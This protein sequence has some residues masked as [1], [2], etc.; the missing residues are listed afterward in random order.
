M[1]VKVSSNNPQFSWILCKNPA[2][3]PVKKDIRQGKGLGFFGVNNPQ[4]YYLHFV[5]GKS[6]SSFTPAEVTRSEPL[7]SSEY[8]HPFA[9]CQLI[10]SLLATAVTDP[11][12]TDTYECTVST[13]VRLA[14][15]RRVRSVAERMGVEIAYMG[16]DAVK[17]TIVKP[18][19]KEALQTTALFCFLLSC[20]HFKASQ[21]VFI[22]EDLLKKYARFAKDLKA[23]YYAKYLL[24][25]QANSQQF[26]AISSILS[27]EGEVFAKGD[28]RAQRFNAVKNYLS[29]SG[30]LYDIGCGELYQSSRLLKDYD[31]LF[32]VDTDEEIQA[33]NREYVDR[34]ELPIV[35]L[36]E[37]PTE[38][39]AGADFLLTE[40]LEHMSSKEARKL[41]TRIIA[42]SPKNVVVTVPNRSFNPHFG[43]G[44]NEFRHDDHKWEPTLEEF[45]TFI[46]SIPG[47][48]TSLITP[49]GDTIHNTSISLL[50]HLTC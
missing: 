1:L 5:E 9:A 48:R 6:R 4:S 27:D 50:A 29:M 15:G 46:D 41:L 16:G 12:E 39:E 32:A 33:A 3:P 7:D 11:N 45:Q 36:L 24:L 18:S 10:T 47:V 31:T 40:V 35:L 20:L 23:P 25:L 2:S 26:N 43:L 13:M 49:V 21:A 44:D 14:G 28:T 38:L 30:T 17:L 19:I 22:S 34:K 37:L 42:S 8:L